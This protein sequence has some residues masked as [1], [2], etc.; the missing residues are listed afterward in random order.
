[1]AVKTD[2]HLILH[3]S[4]GALVTVAISIAPD[5]GFQRKSMFMQTKPAHIPKYMLSKFKTQIVRW[6]KGAHPFRTWVRKSAWKC[7]RGQANQEW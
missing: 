3:C 2:M 5:R 1:L 7:R 4:T 6:H